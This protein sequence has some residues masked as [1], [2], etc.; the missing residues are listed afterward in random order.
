MS[1]IRRSVRIAT[2]ASTAAKATKAVTPVKAM[3][4]MIPSAP[5]KASRTRVKEVKLTH[6]YKMSIGGRLEYYTMLL[7]E[8]PIDMYFHSM[9]ARAKFRTAIQEIA[10]DINGVIDKMMS[11]K[12]DLD[13]MEINGLTEDD[14]RVQHKRQLIVQQVTL[15]HRFLAYLDKAKYGALQYR[16]ALEEDGWDIA[17]AQENIADIHYAIERL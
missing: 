16:T 11:W 14:V 7:E 9:E 8:I 4:R 2:L 10:Y 6:T 1:A 13:E 5:Q 15:I 17:L 12:I 3:V